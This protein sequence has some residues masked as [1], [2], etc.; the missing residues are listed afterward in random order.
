MGLVLEVLTG[1]T[2]S[3]HWQ[4]P[5]AQTFRR[6]IT[7]TSAG[8]HGPEAG[9]YAFWLHLC[10]GFVWAF[11]IPEF[12]LRLEPDVSTVGCSNVSML[13]LN[14]GY[15]HIA[16]LQLSTWF[17]LD[18]WPLAISQGRQKLRKLKA[19]LGEAAR[20]LTLVAVNPAS[21]IELAVGWMVWVMLL[22][23]MDGVMIWTPICQWWFDLVPSIFRNAFLSEEWGKIYEF[24]AGCKSWV[25]STTFQ[26]VQWQAGASQWC[27]WCL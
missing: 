27:R 3:S 12:Y 23:I 22:G 8:N 2:F 9:V 7:Q 6:V 24:D 10:W 21:T 1:G 18:L 14:S 5:S 26:Y 15:D 20:K 19:C 17:H 16:V 25:A 13:P 11:L 4:V